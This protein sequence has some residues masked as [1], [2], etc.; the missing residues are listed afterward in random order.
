MSLA[1]N[2][3]LTLIYAMKTIV[4]TINEHYFYAKSTCVIHPPQ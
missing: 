2:K 1:K 4:Q 3:E